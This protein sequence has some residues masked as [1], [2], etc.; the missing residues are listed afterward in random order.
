MYAVS[1]CL[2]GVNCKYNGKNNEVEE[3][4]KLYE[5]G[6]A[7]LICPECEGGL[8]TPRVPSEICG[9]RVMTQDGRDVTREYVE[10]SLRC[11]K[12]CQQAHC[13]SLILKAMSPSCGVKGVYDGTF[14]HT[15]VEK[16]GVF[17]KMAREAGFF[18]MSDREFLQKGK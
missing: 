9:D 8:P 6:K 14:S 18:C 17:A 16:D 12:K 4:R 5:E 10:G 11:L 15:V 2:A 7:I 13:D 1:A 3:I